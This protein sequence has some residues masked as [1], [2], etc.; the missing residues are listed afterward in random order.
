MFGMGKDSSK[1]TKSAF[2]CSTKSAL[3]YTKK[4]IFG[5]MLFTENQPFDPSLSSEKSLH[6]HADCGNAYCH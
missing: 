4:A 1:A 2:W 5:C 3:L 6:I